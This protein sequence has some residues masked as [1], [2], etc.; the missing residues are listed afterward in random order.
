MKK[1]K[2]TINQLEK[3]VVTSFSYRGVLHKIGLREAGGNYAQV[4]KYITEYDL[5]ITHFRGQAWNKGL[6]GLGK[7][8]IPIEKIL[9]ENSSFQSYK[10]KRRLFGAKLKE[11]KCEECGWAKIS[12]D[13]RLPLELDHINGDSRDNRLDNLRILCPNCHSLKLTHRGKNRKHKSGR[14]AE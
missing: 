6:K 5:N 4:K 12:I 7:S 2:W 9:V 3:A 13:G 14:V 8:I 1:R 10:L 11:P